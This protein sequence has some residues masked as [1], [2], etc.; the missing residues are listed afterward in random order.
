M[1]LLLII[2]LFPI[3]GVSQSYEE[4]IFA[5]RYSLGLGIHEGGSEIG[6]GFIGSFGISKSIGKK[7]KS[8]INTNLSLGRFSDL[9]ITDVPSQKYL[10]T[11]LGF[12]YHFD[13]L[14]YRAFSIVTSVGGQFCLTKGRVE[15]FWSK[16]G[17]HYP[18]YNFAHPYLMASI[19]GGLRIAPKSSR[20][21]F[22]I[23]PFNIYIG[24]SSSYMGTFRI[25]LDYKINK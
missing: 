11:S 12:T 1:K 21:A 9:F 6:L 4:K 8:R 15:A 20:V 10:Y 13:L 14:R 5:Q 24:T 19:S 3:I 16:E 17:I 2:L 25:N 22:E 23:S 18:A 7:K